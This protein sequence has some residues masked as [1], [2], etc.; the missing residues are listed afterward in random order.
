MEFLPALVSDLRFR[1]SEFY[2]R[3]VEETEEER[4]IV[5]D[6]RR[7]FDRTSTSEGVLSLLVVC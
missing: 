4:R 1:S 3:D 2:F 7:L 5:T 6:P